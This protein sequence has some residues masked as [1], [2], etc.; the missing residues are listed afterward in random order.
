MTTA[1]ALSSRILP[2][3]HQAI[4]GPPTSAH[5]AALCA[6]ILRTALGD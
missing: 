3:F 2:A 4:N 6:V 1:I 5:W